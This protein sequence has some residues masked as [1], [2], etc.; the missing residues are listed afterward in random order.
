MFPEYNETI[1]LMANL[2][3]AGFIAV[4]VIVAGAAFLLL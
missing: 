4:A 1:L 3:I 2:G